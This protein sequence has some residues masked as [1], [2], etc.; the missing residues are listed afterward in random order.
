MKTTRDWATELAEEMDEKDFGG[1]EI[2][3]VIESVLK[4]Y[5]VEVLEE[6]EKAI[7]PHNL[8]DLVVSSFASKIRDLKEK[9]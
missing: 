4:R 1:L 8:D 7:N 5:R 6:A 9:P 2:I 3:S